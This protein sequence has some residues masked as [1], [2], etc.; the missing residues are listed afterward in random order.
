MPRVSMSF[1]REDV[2]LIL[3]HKVS[4]LTEPLGDVDADIRLY[5]REGNQVAIPAMEVEVVTP[6]SDG[7]ITYLVGEEEPVDPDADTILAPR[8]MDAFHPQG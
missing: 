1:S 7:S 2:Q 5:D 8:G 6:P 4:E 3:A